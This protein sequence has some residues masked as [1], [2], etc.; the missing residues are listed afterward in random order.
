MSVP[1]RSSQ[2]CRRCPANCL[3]RY[4]RAL[5][6]RIV[7]LESQIPDKRPENFSASQQT[8]TQESPHQRG[9]E[10][11]HDSQASLASR[12]PYPCSMPHARASSDSAT[13]RCLAPGASLAS[14]FPHVVEGLPDIH[15]QCGHSSLLIGILATL[16]G[17]ETSGYLQTQSE[18]P[19]APIFS[20]FIK[21]VSQADRVPRLS[22]ETSDRLVQIY[23]E[24]V[25][26]RYPFL[27]LATFLGWYESW[28]SRSQIDRARRQQSLWK[29][30]FVTMVWIKY[31][32][33]RIYTNLPYIV[34]ACCCPT[35]N[36]SC[37]CR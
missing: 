34:G 13:L 4:T 1:S 32:L 10:T 28:K 2:P 37:L 29:D 14:P 11:D 21:Q 17:N 31:S 36:T 18:G 8:P 33:I 5:E 25:N 27:H 9:N 7:D 19:N 26:P 20:Q 23:L 35:S 24:R 22:N 12:P 15:A 6:E 16:T 30:Y 3:Y